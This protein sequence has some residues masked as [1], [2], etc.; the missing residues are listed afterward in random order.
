[1]LRR[2][3]GIP[4]II[5]MKVDSTAMG[6]AVVGEVLAADAVDRVCSAGYGQRSIDAVRAALPQ[7]ATSASHPE[8][9]IGVYRSL[10]RWPIRRAP[11]TTYQL[12]ERAGML[13]VVSPR[14]IRHAHRAGLAVQVWTVDDEADMERLLGWGADA[15]ITNRPDLAVRVRDASGERRLRREG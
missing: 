6:E 3:P 1:V 7:I 15:L 2:F 14:F 9:R 13:R 8:A 5:E 11:Y 10:A 4:I 12:P